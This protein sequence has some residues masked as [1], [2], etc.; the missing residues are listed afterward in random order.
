MLNKSGKFHFAIEQVDAQWEFYDTDAG[1]PEVT[2]E[3]MDLYQNDKEHA[4]V[5]T[6][7]KDAQRYSA[8]ELFGWTLQQLDKKPEDYMPP[9]AF[10]EALETGELSR[11]ITFPI[12]F[13]PTSLQMNTDQGL[14]DLKKLT[15]TVRFTIALVRQV[16]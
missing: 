4:R 8:N 11:N 2:P 7:A 1:A 15:L 5:F 9:E 10:E 6:Q 12:D 13:T 14:V 16:H 3:D